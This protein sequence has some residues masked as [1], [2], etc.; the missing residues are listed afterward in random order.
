[1]RHGLCARRS[2]GARLVFRVALLAIT[3]AFPC[4]RAHADL[5]RWADPALPVQKHLLLWIDAGRQAAAGA[6]AGLSSSLHGPPVGI[7]YDGSGQGR[8]LQQRSGD[9]QPRLLGAPGRSVLRFDG[10]DDC[11]ERSGL[12]LKAEALTLFVV[13]APRSNLG[14]F[15]GLLSA[16]QAGVNDYRSGFTLDLGPAGGTRFDFLNVEGKGFTGAANVL[17]ETHGFGR[18]HVLEVFIPSGPG[19]ITTALDGQPQNARP[20]E[21]GAMDLDELTLGAR[22]YSNEPRPVYLQGFLDGDVAEV[23]IYGRDLDAAERRAVTSYLTDKHRGLTEAIEKES[24]STGS[25]ALRSLADPPPFQV[26]LPGFSVRELPIKLANINNLRYRSD[27]KLIALGY[28]GNVYVLSDRDGDGLEDHSELFWEGKGRLRGPIGMT[29]T[30]AGYARGS[31][32]FVA[33]KGKLSLIV[34]EDGDDRADREVVVAEGW[35]EIAQAVDALGVAIAPDGSLY[36]GLGTADYTN[37]YLKDDRGKA[38]YDLKSERGTILKLSPDFRTREIVATGIRFPVGLAFNRQGDLFVTDQEGATWLPNGNPFDELL[39]IRPGRHYGF[40]PRHSQHLPGVFDE[41]STFDFA[42][43]HQ[44]T[45]GLCFNEPA[46]GGRVF[47]PEWWAGNAIVCGYSRGKLFRTELV[48]VRGEYVAR[49]TLLAVAGMLLVDSCVAPSGGLVV[50]AHSGAPDWGSGPDGPGKI[51]RIDFDGPQLPQ[52]VLVWPGGLHETRI[53]FDRP[54][55][56][57]LLADLSR[58]IHIESGA[59]VSAGDRFE[60]LRPG[61]AVVAAQL[62]LPRHDLKVQ[63]VSVTPDRRTL[64]VATDPQAEAI[65]YALTLPG[66]GRPARPASGDRTLPQ[67]AELDLAFNLSGCAAKWASADGASSWAGWLPHLDLDVARSFTAGSPEHDAFWPRLEQ[68]GTLELSVQLRLADLLRPAVQPGSVVDDRLPPEQAVVVFRSSGD[69]KVSSALGKLA[70]SQWRERGREITLSLAA[71]PDQL[72]PLELRLPTGSGTTL[73]V[74]YHTSEDSRPRALPLSRILVPW[75][76][77]TAE[78]SS[79]AARGLPPALAGGDFHRGR[80][81]FRSNEGQCS[82][83]HTIHG[84]GGKIGPDLSNLAER[85]LDSVLRDIS[86]PS[87]A[88]HPDYLNY[89]LALADGRVLNGPIRTEGDRLRVGNEKGEETVINRA[90]VE[91]LKPQ[92]VSVMPEGLVK[93]LGPAR[94][95][96]LLTFLMTPPPAPAPIHRDDAPP[97]RLRAEVEALLRGGD[98]TRAAPVR[99]LRI[100][101]L[102]GPKD[103][104]IDEHDYPLWLDR[105]AALLRMAE[106]VEVS[107][108]RDWPSA[109]A[110]E[111]TDVLVLNSA[112]LACSSEQMHELDRF[113]ARG[114]GLVVVHYALNGNQAPEELARRIGLA[115]V[116]GK[117][118]FR[119]GPLKLDFSTEPHPITHGMKTL[120]L[121]DESYWD[122]TGDPSSATILANGQEDGAARPLVWTREAGRGRVFCCVPGHYTWTFDDP[123]YRLLLLRGICWTT[124]QP[125]DRLSSLATLGARMNGV[126]E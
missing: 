42:P 16:N 98:L 55:E 60:T 84:D 37:A 5:E 65:S 50:A 62:A 10:K 8:H 63:G 92:A 58:K 61:Y 106:G 114:G 18:F 126:K 99:P 33:S 108:G 21:P 46:V 124:N 2:C 51:F 34:D 35:K 59:A 47:G 25:H 15:R 83:C 115:W 52:P 31:G 119:H 80:E 104:G 38:H 43:Q 67:L 40:P 19:M 93:T 109:E 112:G 1:M 7:A 9:A 64:V 120:S 27:G 111:K 97:P 22:C 12:G 88:I 101:L 6:A 118:K 4:G 74:E 39:H 122:L 85:D 105:W 117:S 44:S 69:L 87:A 49:S 70:S 53:T 102:G 89:S 11:L 66:L 29:L 13:A 26:L 76:R 91:E 23:L 3:F 77:L 125:V 81:V 95:K 71:R 32:L 116:G 75:A 90:D 72:V 100:A 30:P 103:H 94:L 48:K 54:I 73:E 110:L 123:L 14:A 68:P 57:A 20:R 82:K 41:P 45:C 107:S 121:V 56:P 28:N 24:D 79:E 78:P 113:L 96:D 17:K 86:Q 36:F